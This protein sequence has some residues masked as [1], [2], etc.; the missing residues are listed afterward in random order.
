[1]WAHTLTGWPARS[2]S[3]PAASSRRIASCRPS[4]Y[5]CSLVRVS[6]AP[7]GAAS[8]S[9][10]AVTTAAHS[11]VKSP[12]STPAPPN[13][14]STV[15]RRSSNADSVSPSCSGRD[16]AYISAASSASPAKSAPAADAATKIASA[17]SRQSPG[18]LSVQ[19]HS[20]RA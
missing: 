15:T 17:A 3:S 6:S 16:R 10:T 7:T 13:V 18:S 12:F 1:M 5:R 20:F 11:G 2:G 9:S 4:W 19:S 14:V 8:D